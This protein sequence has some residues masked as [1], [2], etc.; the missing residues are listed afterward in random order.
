MTTL[1]KNWNLPHK[2]ND[3]TPIF[4]EFRELTDKYKCQSFG[5]GAPG[6]QPPDFL[7]EEIVRAIDEGFN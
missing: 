1:G 5:E 6:Y 2:L 3:Y 4:S 7:K